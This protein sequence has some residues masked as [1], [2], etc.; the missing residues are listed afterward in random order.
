V[1]Y[2]AA[3]GTAISGIDYTPA[4]GTLTFAGTAGETQTFIVDPT[5]DAIVEA[6]ETF[7]INLSSVTPLGTGVDAGDID[8]TDTATGTITNDDT[9][10]LTV[11]DVS[12]AEDGPNLT[13][14]VTLSEAVQDG[15]TV[16][17]AAASGTAISGNDY[18]PAS[19]TLTFAGTAGETQTFVVDPT[20]D[21][22]VES[23]ETFTIK[24][25]SV[26]PL[27]TGVD[28]ADIDAND[29]ATGTITNDDTTALTV[30]DVSGTE[31][32]SDLTFTV[33]L[34]AGVQDGF[35]VNY[36]TASGTAISGTDFTP[37]SGTLTFA[38]T[39]G[40]TRTFTVDPTADTIVEGDETFTI[41]LSLVAPL[42]TGVDAGDI[43]A[44]DTAT[45]TI[46]NDD[47]TTLTVADVSGAEDGP[48]LT[49]TVTLFAGV[50]D[51]FTV[52]YT[53]VSG[54][55]ISGTDFTPASGT[56]TFA[57]TAGETQTFTVD[58][59][60]DT[61][62]E[63]DET[64]TINLSSIIPGGTGGIVGDINALDAA[65]GTIINDDTTTL[66]VA[67]VSGAEDGPNLTFAVALS[68]DVQDG[69]TVNYN[70]ASGTAVSG[71]DFTPASGTLT[72]AGTTGETQT[73]IVDPTADTIVEG[74]ETFT[75][76]LSSITPL[77]TGVD[78]A[79]IDAT[80]T[81][82]GT[83][84]N[85]DTTALTV[86]DVSGTEDGPDLTFTVTLSAGVQDGFT[87]NYETASGTA[88][89]G[90]DFTPASGTLTFAGT[91]G[92]TRTFTVDPT[93]DSIVEGDE[94]FAVNLSSITPLGTGVVAGDIDASD[95]AT[96]TI[97][98]DD[99]T[100]LTVS[101]VSGAEDGPNLTFT[102]TLLGDVQDG[103]TVN[104]DA[105]SGT[106]ISGIDFAPASGTLTFAGS[107]GETQTFTVDP[108]ADNIAEADETFT[109]NLSAVT[110]LVTGV[111]PADIIASEAGTGTIVNDD[112]TTLTVADVTGAEDG[113][114]LTF[115]V[116]LSGAVQ[117]GFT[118]DY[119]GASGTAI[120][121]TDFVPASGTLTFAGT[122]GETQT[123]TV[124]PTAD[125]I[126]EADETFT[127]NLSSVTPLGTGVGAGDIDATDTA[128]GTIT[129]DDATTLTVT[130]VSGTEDGPD[131]TFT[132]AL[133]AG[134]QDGFTVDYDTA[135]GTAMSGTDFTPASGTL[136]FGGSAGETQTFTVDPT[137]D[138]IVEA[139]ETFTI[140]L[141]AV[142]TFGAG[143][144]AADVDAS[145]T[146]T[147]TITND[148]TTTLTVADVSGAE[149]GANF[150]FTVVLSNAVQDGLIVD[151]AA[152][153]GTA[154][155]GTDFTPASG[156]LTFA[157]TA[158]ETQTFTVDPT[159]DTVVE[160]DETFT[161]N[162]SS[163][164]PLGTGVDF[165]AI[166]ATDTATGTI[167]N[168]DATT[169][170]VADVS[171]AEDGPDLTFTVTLSA[172]VQDGFTVD[173][174]TISG[175]AIS[176]TDFTPA[177]GTLTF[178]GTAGETQTFTVDPT[179]DTIV[180]DDETFLIN[181]SSV[182]PGGTGGIVGDINALDAAT[183]T[184][185]NDDTATLT[186]ADVSG[187][188]D[189]SNLTFTVTLSNAVDGGLTVN[190]D[191]AS[192]TATSGMDFAPASGT[193][194]FAGTAG[195]TQ[196]FTVDPTADTIVE[197]D[198]TFTINLSSVTPLGTGVDAS[199][200][201]ATDTATGTITN[202][203]TASLTVEDVS[204][205]ED[206]PDL[207]FVVTLSNAVQDGF[208]VDYEAASGTAIS[209]TDFTPA[210]GTLTFAGTMG[211]TQTFTVDPTADTIVEADETFT[212]NLSSVTPLG[213]GVDAA[214][215][216][217]T[218]TATGT[219]IDDDTLVA[220]KA[221]D[222]VKREGTTGVTTM[223]T[224]T[225]TR[226]GDTSGTGIVTWTVSGV[227]PNPADMNDFVGGTF[228]TDTV[229]FMA[230]D[231]TR[232]I[233]VPV[234]GDT[235]VEPDENFQVSLS[236]PI[237]VDLMPGMETADG[238]IIENDDIA[239]EA[240]VYI[241]DDWTGLSNNDIVPVPG[242]SATIGTNAFATVP[243]GFD[244]V[245]SDGTVF[246]FD[247]NY[248]QVTVV[249]RAV[250]VQ[251]ENEREML[252]NSVIQGTRATLL[253]VGSLGVDN[254]S[255]DT[256]DL[257]Q[258]QVF[259]NRTAATNVTTGGNTF[260]LPED[261]AIAVVTFSGN[262][263]ISLDDTELD[264]QVY[265]GDGSD[266][267]FT[268]SG[269]DFVVAGLGNDYVLT[270]DGN[271]VLLGGDGRDQLTAGGGR[272]IL[273]SN[274]ADTFTTM[275]FFQLQA[276]W[277]DN[278]VTDNAA[279][280][281]A[282]AAAI[283][284]TGD[285]MDRD[286]ITGGQGADLLSYTA[287]GSAAQRDRLATPLDPEDDDSGLTL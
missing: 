189:G 86:A 33:T 191:A 54:T 212:I 102:V 20:A 98:N 58:P 140:N 12:G 127:I 48:D 77:G 14:V 224:F 234:R 39:A 109:I 176:G 83:I 236:N 250:T 199:D 197:A 57:G 130:D 137:A 84:T 131:L 92:E 63:A 23:D 258:A 167:T 123:F 64:F 193:L 277:A 116:L 101:D 243:D 34:S 94:T 30:A 171:G 162:L 228:P 246:L 165:A 215:I 210:S 195:E 46:T 147:G 179:A 15:F 223:F 276:D 203:D 219:I 9:T 85:D 233:S 153:S 66:T 128:T 113:P 93:T 178:T 213:T 45:G 244:A 132:V 229:T 257:T 22:I 112:M 281:A 226:T 211:E 268:G 287:T 166:D 117:D 21:S 103:F 227:G 272:D 26:T 273:V 278:G 74:D 107:A 283:M 245:R 231:T 119:N 111:D 156:T 104:Y 141:S 1:D 106:A 32:G 18:A 239:G 89:S 41:N 65:T 50:Q 10:A 44:S 81:A 187:A 90:T 59:T 142:T 172:G 129:N 118:V 29:T 242:G 110:P 266:Q 133:S 62:V 184:I 69:F 192:G 204:G 51:G 55:A 70:A 180:E 61:I 159:A 139:G 155:S 120:S 13:F 145:D 282:F 35:T 181:L 202:D 31:D 105:V 100:A 190:F 151:Y 24:L 194:T 254:I 134:V 262:D 91:P 188:E 285:D 158:G 42:G 271:D 177:S 28:A 53:T 286:N 96:G 115:T 148:D 7:T 255:A 80:D 222:A 19:G 52:D 4:S 36:E 16:D 185:T 241:D 163:V 265:S 269:D 144:E 253:A 256:E 75:I 8:A 225:I 186:V 169:L 79:D 25:S 49:F 87:V 138:T 76:N 201:D 40:E 208:T 235:D 238:A 220:I 73:F 214:D 43:D 38:G 154:I 218:D 27:G 248:E 122:T 261:S 174:A 280:R 240:I 11:E 82:T 143:V 149:D 237:G 175:T 95:T 207:T 157:G 260:A 275:E 126:V 232:L 270:N 72:F 146:A 160:G 252:L 47:S 152:V 263:Q 3:S 267:V 78:A 173:Y 183:G 170:T 249:D 230:G 124:D 279:L 125:T 264:A 274:G 67:D 5:T 221:T 200:I 114:N 164:T 135:S 71:T 251:I 247:G 99:T 17:Y 108:T 196:T 56:L 217:A 205:A 2:D 182:I 60:A 209:G 136:T 37:A 168:D 68:A 198:E 88:I 150:T 206:G 97:I 284:N 259:F 121:G 216:D 6:D 161:I